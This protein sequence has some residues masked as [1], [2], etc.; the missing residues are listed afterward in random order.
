MKNAPPE[1]DRSARRGLLPA[2]LNHRAAS[3]FSLVELLVVVAVVALLL[4]VLLPGLDNARER[5]RRAKCAASLRQLGYAFHMY[6]V[7]HSGRAMPLAWFQQWPITYW[8]GRERDAA[9]IDATRG[10]V[11]PYL[12][13][14]L[15]EHGILE[16]PEQPLGTFDRLQGAWPTI[17]TTYG[18]NGYFLAP[19]TVPGWAASIGHRPWQ[20]L[21]TLIHPQNITVFADTMIDWNGTLKNCAL[22]DPPMLYQGGG[23]WTRNTRPTTCFRHVWT[24]NFVFADGHVS[25][26]PPA[27]GW[28]QSS[29]F[30]LGSIGYGND[31]HYIPDWRDW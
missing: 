13:G 7:D 12:T 10:F 27:E 9:G 16:C 19:P 6:A 29:E 5:A 25:S 26:Q 11:W 31:P 3:A 18:Y 1:K 24:A 4:G 20:K 2:R 28:I 22:L 15:K 14:D 23:N 21:D 8:Y 30:R 17:T